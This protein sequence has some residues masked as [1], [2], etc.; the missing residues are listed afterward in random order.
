MVVLDCAAT[1]YLIVMLAFETWYCT[2]YV[3][4]FYPNQHWHHIIIA[5]SSISWVEAATAHLTQTCT[6]FKI[7]FWSFFLD[8]LK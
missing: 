6:G 7:H 3:F 8:F 5:L 1:V 2:S 4:F